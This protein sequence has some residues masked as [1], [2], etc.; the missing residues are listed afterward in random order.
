VSEPPGADV[1]IVAA[2]QSRRMGG[3]NKLAEP[4]LGRPLIA[5][6]VA[7]MAAATCLRRLVLVVAPE[8]LET[9]RAWSW[10][11]DGVEIVAGGETRSD[12]VR[13]GL[14][15]TRSDV[16]L[17][18]DGARPLATA[19]L[20]DAVAMAA[21]R[22]GAAVPLVDV[23]DSLKRVEEGWLSGAVER[24]GLQRAQTP[25]AARRQLLLDAFAASEGESFADEA[26][27]LQ[28]RRIPVAAVPGEP[29]NLKVTQPADLDLVRAVLAARAPA[30]ERRGVGYDSHPFGPQDGLWLGGLLIEEAP[31]LYGHSDGDVALHALASALLA[32]AGLG[33]LGRHF[34]PGR[35]ETRG[36]ASTRLLSEVVRIVA[37]AG[38]RPASAQ[39]TLLGARPRLGAVRLQQM[40]EHVAELL[41][42]EREAVS[43]SASSG[44]L[45]GPEGAGR[46]ISA[47]A[48]VSLVRR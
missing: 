31:R 12:S 42:L 47:S 4:V 34:P 26:A 41:E 6:T 22:H 46:A 37:Q 19:G 24:D 20:A 39:L 9:A 8:Q 2:G 14:A 44:N 48:A 29:L 32:A 17:V 45:T 23:V 1:V 30:E 11:P 13:A 5:W 40:L 33:D 16:V 3:P 35:P 27:L 21:G 25:Q 36:V 7:A 43:L 10:L 18:H 38:W 15:V 28:A